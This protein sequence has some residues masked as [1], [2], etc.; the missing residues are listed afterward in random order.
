[1]E[2][3][4]PIVLVKKI[5]NEF[6]FYCSYCGIE[7]RHCAEEGF[8]V[9]HCINKNSPYKKSGYCLVLEDQ[10]KETV[11]RAKADLQ[12]SIDRRRLVKL[13]LEFANGNF[14]KENQEEYKSLLKKIKGI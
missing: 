13:G 11:E 8:R 14:S 10:T 2:N 1:M 6:V 4:I 12:R 7:H 3:N 5:K 9:A